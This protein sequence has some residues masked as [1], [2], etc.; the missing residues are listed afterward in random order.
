MKFVNKVALETYFP[1]ILNQEY[2]IVLSTQ[3]YNLLSF[4]ES[5]ICKQQLQFKFKYIFGCLCICIEWDFMRK[6]ELSRQALSM[7][8]LA[9][10]HL[11]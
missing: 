6:V 9:V 3:K 2:K 10:Y 7:Q 1:D 4:I 5:E 8:I 11:F